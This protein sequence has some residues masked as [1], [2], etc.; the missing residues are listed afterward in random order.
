MDNYSSLN[1]ENLIIHEIIRQNLSDEKQPPIYSEI[2]SPLDDEIRL[3][4]K[5]R[6]TDTVGSSKAHNIVFDESSSSIAPELIKSLLVEEFDSEN[7][8]ESSKRIASH[9]NQIQTGRSPGGFIT[10]VNGINLN[11]RVIGVLK[12]ERE[13]G[14]RLE[15]SER[16]GKKTFEITSVKNL[17]LSQNTRLLKISV[18]YQNL[19]NSEIEGKICDNQLTRKGEVASFFL[20]SFLG[21]KF[22]HDPSIQTKDF[23]RY[24]IQ[25]I[26]EKI[27]D[28]ITQNKYKL[29]LQSYISNQ[30]R[31][32]NP[33]TFAKINLDTAHRQAYENYLIEKEVGIAEIIKDT[34]CIKSDIEKIALE[35][36]NGIQI[37]GNQQDFEEHVSIEHLENGRTKAMV[38]SRLKKIRR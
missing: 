24:S 31:L 34:S 3:F 15:Q 21:C 10:I 17:V 30:E 27:D 1:I 16:D 9:L 20:N 35:F 19:D 12:I 8:V 25:F 26:K 28:P 23:F 14:A 36:E 5:D 6:M 13:Q 29:H 18:F 32:I 37:I 7:F 22:M 33:R 2:E 38:E 4:L 11:R